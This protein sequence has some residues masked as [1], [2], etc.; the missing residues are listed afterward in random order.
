MLP[1]ILPFWFACNIRRNSKA[2][3]YNAFNKFRPSEEGAVSKQQ[4]I[5]ASKRI[6]MMNPWL[7]TERIWHESR[8]AKW[9]PEVPKLF[10]SLVQLEVNLATYSNV[11]IL[12]YP[13]KAVCKRLFSRINQSEQEEQDW[14]VHQPFKIF[15]YCWGVGLADSQRCNSTF[16]LAH[17][18]EL[19]SLQSDCLGRQCPPSTH[20][21]YFSG[22]N[23]GTTPAAAPLDHQ[24]FHSAWVASQHIQFPSARDSG[25][26]SRHH[27][28]RLFSWDC[29][30]SYFA[31]WNHDERNFPVKKF[32]VGQALRDQFACEVLHYNSPAIFGRGAIQLE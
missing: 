22:E 20:R 19:F 5:S 12:L 23:I 10:Q 6:C 17:Q 2:K 27:C 24:P 15:S 1:T 30:V 4:T 11:Q 14:M 28:T 18:K 7:V 26:Y 31:A 3:R 16:A 13:V 21:R 32:A 25:N 9:V 8:N 29:H